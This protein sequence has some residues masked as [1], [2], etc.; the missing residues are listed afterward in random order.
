VV[1]KYWHTYTVEGGQ[2]TILSCNFRDDC[3]L[4]WRWLFYLLNLGRINRCDDKDIGLVVRHMWARCT[5]SNYRASVPIRV[6][7]MM[8]AST[9]LLCLVTVAWT[10]SG[11]TWT[12]ETKLSDDRDDCGLWTGD[13]VRNLLGMD[14]PHS[15]MD[16]SKV[17]EVVIRPDYC[18]GLDHHEAC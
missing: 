9:N 2:P 13:R 15:A 14:C 8:N 1:G 6:L 7:Q 3:L 12:S 16:A 5:L 11:W 4:I 18:W 17:Y 10:K